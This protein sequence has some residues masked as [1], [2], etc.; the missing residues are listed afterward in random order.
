MLTAMVDSSPTDTAASGARPALPRFIDDVGEGDGE[1]GHRGEHPEH[2]AAR[3]RQA[4]CLE[5]LPKAQ[6]S[7]GEDHEERSTPSWISGRAHA[8]R[9]ATMTP[10]RV[11][12]I[13]ET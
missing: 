10:S 7:E 13:V 9:I 1:E 12:T 8:M 4:V 2:D 5:L 11:G 3:P 6:G